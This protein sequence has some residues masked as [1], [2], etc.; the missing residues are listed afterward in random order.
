M[1]KAKG[2]RWQKSIAVTLILI[3]LMI[4][5]SFFVM[6]QL[7]KVEEDNSFKRLNEEAGK[8]A[9]NIE[10]HLQSDREKLELIALM[11]SS[12]EDLS[13]PSLWNML[14]S[15]PATGMLSRLEI[16]LPDDTVLTQGGR[17]VDVS[18][19]LSFAEE[20][21]LG[22]HITDRV[23]DLADDGDYIL[24]HYVPII[25]NGETV[26]ML[27]GVVE[28]DVLPEQ[29]SSVAYANTAVYIIDAN[30]GD[31]LVDT[32]HNEPGNIWALGERPLAPG[33]DHDTLKA[34]LV[35]GETG[36][37]VFVSETAGE[38]LYFYYEPMSVNQWRIA[39]SIPESTVFADAN[40]IRSILNVFLVFEICCFILY[41]AWMLV[42]VRRETQEKQRQLDAI[43]DIYDVEK[44]LFTAHENQDNIRP[45]LQLICRITGGNQVFFWIDGLPG[46]E[47]PFFLRSDTASSLQNNRLFSP[48]GI[49]LLLKKFR[50][51][52]TQ[53]EATHDAEL[54]VLLPSEQVPSVKSLVAVP[55]EAAGG[56][57]CGILAVC[58]TGHRRDTAGL[59]KNIA[60]S[61]SRFCHNMQ[62]YHAVKAMGETDI[63]SGLYNRNRYEADLPEYLHRY[64]TSLACIYIDVNGLHEMNN[65]RGHEAGDD[66]IKQVA[67]QL[68]DAFGPQQTYRIGGDEFVAFSIDTPE[69]EVASR[70]DQMAQAL[71]ERDIHISIGIQWAEAIPSIED[72]IKAAEKKMYT[73]KMAFYQNP[74][75]DRRQ[76][77]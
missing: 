76:R 59:L 73:A 1:K 3:L 23:I 26:A 10:E 37:V 12:Y 6:H 43:N 4:G 33:Y 75:F 42:Y 57:V 28:L 20:A 70:C 46:V 8:L 14:D 63:L 53:F 21:A 49:E 2:I 11:A 60:F 50:G 13:S 71:A 72:F 40:T 9:Q 27:Y 66:M 67:A 45:A 36:Y 41:L 18:G 38:Y 56:G 15:Y 16:L 64:Q 55:I 35:A 19:Q 17:R 24:R 52:D 31:F 48:D 51:G 62:S 29:L 22:A 44:L 7:N 25:Q 58:N 65:S 74:A 61:F 68:L 39:L 47:Q 69:A 34:G 5:V 77:D 54:R 32:W 30:T